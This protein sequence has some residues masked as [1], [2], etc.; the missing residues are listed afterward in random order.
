MLY[1]LHDL[2]RRALRPM[3]AWSRVQARWLRRTPVLGAPFA[4]AGWELVHRLMKE[5]PRP[6]FDVRSVEL[7]GETLAVSEQVV[8]ATPFCSL[9][10][11]AR[12]SA[13]DAVQA[14]LDGQPRVLLCAPLSGHHAT[15]LRDTVRAL[16]PHHDLYVTDWSDAKDVPPAAGRFGLDD[17]VEHLMAFIRELGAAD[18]SVI[19]VCQPTV[20]ALAA[21]SLL[22]SAGEA[23]P[24]ALVLMGGP[25]DG[26]I[27]P[28][29]VN[30]LA[31]EHPL[32]WFEQNLV[33]EVPP[34]HPGAGRRVYPGFLQLGA[35]VSMNKRKHAD[36]YRRYWLCRIS[37]EDSSAASHE[38][39]YD[40]YNAVLDMDADF[41]LDTV[42]E[43]FQSFSLPR[44]TWRVRG[45]RVAPEDIRDTALLTVEGAEDDITGPGQ[46]HAA[47]AL[48]TGIPDHAK[49]ALT[50]PGC[51]HYGIFSGRKFRDSIAPVLCAFV[52][53]HQ[54][55][56]PAATL[57][58]DAGAAC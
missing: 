53:E 13:S 38:R 41:Y 30:R 51:G 2:S 19:A 7:D 33:Y 10:R 16:A 36:A 23:T 58:A 55:P 1:E 52:R 12:R 24:R 17:Y 9:V 14:R 29:A 40:E 46:T 28:T 54:R 47:L 20:P 48:C 22:A 11:F 57:P 25:V 31:T 42:R 56:R 4:A 50:M 21:V 35:F 43:V 49:R 18:L 39:F 5:Y 26:R 34:G 3:A 6:A 44:G 15:L 45:S 32:R 27:S 37:G 8:A